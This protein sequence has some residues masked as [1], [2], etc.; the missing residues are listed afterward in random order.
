MVEGSMT[1]FLAVLCSLR[2]GRWDCKGKLWRL[3]LVVI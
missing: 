3:L 2:C 1:V